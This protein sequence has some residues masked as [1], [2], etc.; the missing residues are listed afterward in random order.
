MPITM[1]TITE[2]KPTSSDSRV[3]YMIEESTS[4]PWSSVP[5]GKV[6]SPSSDNSTGGFRPSLRLSVAGSKGVC[7]ASTGDRNATTMMKTVAAAAVMVIGEDLKLHQMSLSVSRCSHPW[8][9][10]AGVV[11]M[12]VAR[13]RSEEHTSEL[14]SLRHLVCR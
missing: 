13:H 8:D 1:A 14:Q 12:S 6:Q 10:G 5:S 2:K 11:D 4:L 3:P 9:A 7:G